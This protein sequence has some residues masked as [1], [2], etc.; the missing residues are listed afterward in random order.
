MTEEITTPETPEVPTS[1][2]AYINTDGTYKDGWKDVLLP[3]ELR[4][5]KFY[6][7]PFNANV[8]ELLKTAGNQAKMLGK[9]GVVPINDKSTEFEV[10]EYRRAMNVPDKYNY[11]KPDIEML[12]DKDDILSAMHD[13]WNKKNLSQEQVDVVMEDFHNILKTTEAQKQAAEI[14]ESAEQDRQILTEENTNYEVNSHYIDNAVRKFT[15]GWMDDD[16]LALFPSKEHPV[17][18]FNGNKRLLI[19]KFL[20]NVGQAM[21]EGRMVTGDTIGPPIQQQL[22]EVM[23]SD[24]YKTGFG[25]E[26]NEAVAKASK[27]FAEIA[28]QQGRTL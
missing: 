6:D 20:A 9:K 14:A 7:S 23:K 3:E 28:K 4:T 8:K 27:L 11:E 10:K 16:I 25:K 22:D 24:A 18:D 17:A 26:H 15:E 19:R 1:G 21:G 2:E 13:K 12:K 5:E